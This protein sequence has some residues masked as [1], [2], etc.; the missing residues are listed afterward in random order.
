MGK[1]TRKDL[2]TENSGKFE[3]WRKIALLTAGFFIL[4][5]FYGLTM[6]KTDVNSSFLQNIPVYLLLIGYIIP[7][8]ALKS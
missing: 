6:L 4:A 3:T 8:F 2:D 1:K 7:I 5:G